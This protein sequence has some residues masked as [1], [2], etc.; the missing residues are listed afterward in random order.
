MDREIPQQTNEK[1]PINPFPN[2]LLC[3]QIMARFLL[4]VKH[5]YWPM[6][7]E[8]KA[9]WTIDHDVGVSEFRHVNPYVDHA[10]QV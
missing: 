8:R 3:M 6:E 1:I 7:K 5:I 2:N 9:S 4:V 10:V